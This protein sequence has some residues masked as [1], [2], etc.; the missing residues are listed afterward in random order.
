MHADPNKETVSFMGKGLPL[1]PFGHLSVV[2]R[3]VGHFLNCLLRLGPVL[4]K[5]LHPS[6][7][8]IQV[9]FVRILSALER[10]EVGHGRAETTKTA[11]S[12]ASKWACSS[13]SSEQGDAP[14]SAGQWCDFT[15]RTRTLHASLRT[16][17]V[18]PGVRTE[19]EEL[20]ARRTP[21]CLHRSAVIHVL[22]SHLASLGTKPWESNFRPRSP[23]CFVNL[24][25]LPWRNASAG[26]FTFSVLHVSS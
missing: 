6:N 12:M 18:R 25:F 21:R 11:G 19:K 17:G 3:H 13:G 22:S 10:H 9:S 15:F 1:E 8:S 24:F 7:H 26:Q 14:P 2:Q 20:C 23:S 4:A 5:A 16:F